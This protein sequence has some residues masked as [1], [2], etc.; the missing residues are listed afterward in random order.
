M[1]PHWRLWH[2][3]SKNDNRLKNQW[4]VQQRPVSLATSCGVKTHCVKPPI[5]FPFISNA[6]P[7]QTQPARNRWVACLPRE[8]KFSLASERFAVLLTLFI[9]MVV[10][11]WISPHSL[12]DDDAFFPTKVWHVGEL[13]VCCLAVATS[14]VFFWRTQEKHILRPP[15]F[16]ITAYL[17]LLALHASLF[18]ILLAMYCLHDLLH[19]LTA[20]TK[21]S[22]MAP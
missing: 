11:R 16:G 10:G 13:T 17:H 6:G 4:H 5:P 9:H 3:R 21:V 19:E 2:R 8:V 15:S 22:T 1:V 18:A 7:R 12:A 20:P 14:Y